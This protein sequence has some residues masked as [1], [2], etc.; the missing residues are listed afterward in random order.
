MTT[1]LA[2]GKS[3]VL[4]QEAMGHSTIQ[5]TMGYTHLARTHLRTLIDEPA[6]P[7]ELKELAR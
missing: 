1:W 5:V 4:V 6:A 3:P 2:K 7:A